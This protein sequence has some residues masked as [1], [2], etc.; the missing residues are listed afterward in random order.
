MWFL[1]TIWT[2]TSTICSDD[3]WCWHKRCPQV[4]T[5]WLAY[6]GQRTT[7]SGEL[8]TDSTGSTTSRSIRLFRL[9]RSS[10]AVCYS[11]VDSSRSASG[12]ICACKRY[13]WCTP[14]SRSSF[15]FTTL[16]RPMCS[17]WR[18]CKSSLESLEASQ[19]EQS[20]WMHLWHRMFWIRTEPSSSTEDYAGCCMST[21]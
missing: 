11:L 19:V 18:S 5:R 17:S 16:A 6:P 3:G 12:C 21:T 15:S 20:N 2:P 13:M 14:P 8:L 7:N 9:F 4:T 1:T 10:H